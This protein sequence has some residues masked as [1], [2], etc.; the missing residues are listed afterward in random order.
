M[1]KQIV[2][3]LIP[4]IIFSFVFYSCE[5]IATLF[6]GGKPEII[7]LPSPPDTPTD[8]KLLG[9]Y[10]D[11]PDV[12]LG[13]SSVSEAKGYYVYRSLSGLGSYTKV[14]SSNTNSYTDTEVKANTTYYYKVSAYNDAGE[15]SQ[16]LYLSVFTRHGLQPFN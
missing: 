13:W 6:H 3:I 14:G 1:K 4:V 5:N 8:L 11:R 2:R 7:I 12:E 15:S 9:G 16:S 10:T